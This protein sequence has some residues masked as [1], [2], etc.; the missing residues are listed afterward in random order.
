MRP[1]GDAGCVLFEGWWA[2]GGSGGE[3]LPESQVGGGSRP[4]HTHC[5]CWSTARMLRLV[6]AA[7]SWTRYFV[8]FSVKFIRVCVCV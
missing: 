7:L 5:E 3:F 4:S 6:L 8:R 2:S 1:V